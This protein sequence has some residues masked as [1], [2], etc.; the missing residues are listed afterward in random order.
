MRN[1]EKEKTFTDKTKYSISTANQT[2]KK[3]LP[4][5]KKKTTTNIKRKN[6][7]LNSNYNKYVGDTQ[8]TKKI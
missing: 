8:H 1:Y 3:P 5:K 7:K 6:V 2:F 4:K